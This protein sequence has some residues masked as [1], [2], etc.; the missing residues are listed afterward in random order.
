MMKLLPA[1]LPLLL[2][3]PAAAAQPALRVLA[4]GVSITRIP[5]P[6]ELKL[7][8]EAGFELDPR[9]APVLLA[10]GKL[11]NP[12][13]GSSILPS[14]DASTVDAFAFLPAGGLLTVSRSKLGFV[15]ESGV[16]EKVE[17]PAPGM[18][19]A[20]RN[21]QTVV[22]YGG[23]A[24]PDN[25]VYLYRSDGTYRK[26]V[27][28]AGKIGSLAALPERIIFSVG[29][30]VFDLAPG[31]PPKPVLMLPGERIRSLAFSSTGGLFYVSTENGIFLAGEKRVLPLVTGA[32]CVLRPAKDAVIY[33]LCP[34]LSTFLRMTL[35]IDVLTGAAPAAGAEPGWKR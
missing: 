20:A 10:G 26:L 9:G 18:Q 4:K 3:T 29:S 8:A 24:R 34:K 25:A 2:A 14:L 30:A 28:A 19:L 11:L 16:I 27:E 7:P 33:A 6:K 31:S 21:D 32:S 13:D 1:L 12:L 35:A 5:L 23:S 22:V 15:G 17:L